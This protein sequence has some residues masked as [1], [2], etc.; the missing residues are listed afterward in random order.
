M[1]LPPPHGAPLAPPMPHGAPFAP[2]TPHGVPVPAH[3]GAPLEPLRAGRLLDRRHWLLAGL[4][5]I[6]GG[7]IVL[8]QSQGAL[9]TL[10]LRPEAYGWDV[11]SHQLGIVVFGLA[12]TAAAYLLAPGG[13]VGRLLG[14]VVLVVLVAAGFVLQQAVLSGAG[15]PM[16]TR[17]VVSGSSLV[18]LGGVA[19]WILASGARWW[20]WAAVLLVPVLAVVP[21]AGARAGIPSGT[22]SWLMSGAA[23]LVALLTL[24]LTVPRRR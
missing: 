18:L 15:L 21:T 5:G 3:P 22:V 16:W 23:L 9:V 12:A 13:I 6:T 24:A 17:W 14:V 8:Q 7:A 10:L 1:T 11:L 19:G 4:L 2:P 20:A